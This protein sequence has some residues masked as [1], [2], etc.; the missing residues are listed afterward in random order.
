MKPPSAAVV[1][2]ASTTQW[3]DRSASTRTFWPATA[4]V[5]VPWSA[6]APPNGAGFDGV[7]SVSAPGP[8]ASTWLVAEAVWPAAVAVSVTVYE[9]ACA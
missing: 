6:A 7:A 8:I 5:S 3:P 4:G 1:A 2:T 9:P